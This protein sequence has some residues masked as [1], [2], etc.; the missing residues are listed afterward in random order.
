MLVY[1]KNKEKDE[2]T[3]KIH[4]KSL[5]AISYDVFYVVLSI[6]TWISCITNDKQK[7]YLW[8]LPIVY[9]FT[10]ILFIAGRK[11]RFKLGIIIINAIAF[12]RYNV[13]PFSYYFFNNHIR[14]NNLE[15]EIV[16]MCVELISVY[17]TI[18]I[19]APKFLYDK[20]LENK[21]TFE[22]IEKDKIF[23]IST[24]IVLI[25]GF[26]S[27]V[28]NPVLLQRIL[29][30]LG[31]IDI[32]YINNGIIMIYSTAIIVS[33]LWIL[34]KIKNSKLFKENIKIILSLC[35][36]GVSLPIFSAGVSGHVSRMGMLL[37]GIIMLV[38]LMNLYKKYS[39][40]ILL[41]MGALF[42]VVLV[43]GTAW[44]FYEEPK[45]V[46]KVEIVEELVDYRMLNIYLS[47]PDNISTAI[48]TKEKFDNVITART[49]VND[50][51][52]NAPIITG[53]LDATNNYIPKYFNYTFYNSF[54]ANDQICPLVGQSYIYFGIILFPILSILA[55]F[56][57]LIFSKK[58]TECKNIF[59]Y[60]GYMIL[61]INTAMFMSIN[62]NIIL[63]YFWINALPL[64][65]LGKLNCKIK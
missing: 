50:I 47:G 1:E 62:L 26:C 46:S 6:I 65:I 8:I 63:Q 20:D 49:F 48:D 56:A 27:I 31:G 32:S 21:Y 14:N 13:L 36:L 25:I 39:K 53:V 30:P 10:Y 16:L 54:I 42:V 23:G 61:V 18:S 40:V 33:I 59:E 9:L 57:V 55:T 38:I 5:F 43:F 11:Y 35:I 12:A 7:S 28:K 58:L 41:Y 44:K 37:N 17:T 45:S 15:T 2:V 29:N 34:L 19:F 3:M 24:V 4:N 52:G 22:K 60:Y 51:F 64:I